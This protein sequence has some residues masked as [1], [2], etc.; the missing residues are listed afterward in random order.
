MHCAQP[1]ANISFRQ[2]Q[3]SRPFSLL[4]CRFWTSSFRFRLAIR[5]SSEDILWRRDTRSKFRFFY[6]LLFC[7]SLSRRC[8]YN[9]IDFRVDGGANIYI[10]YAIASN[11]FTFFRWQNTLFSRLLLANNNN[12]CLKLP[13]LIFFF[14]NCDLKIALLYREF[15][16]CTLRK[17]FRDK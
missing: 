10:C 16:R 3:Q 4:F 13:V 17:S 5:A 15:L 11:N 12:N 9:I 8:D 14:F 2:Q 7:W 6:F 1:P